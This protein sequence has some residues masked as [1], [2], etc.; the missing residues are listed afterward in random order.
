MCGKFPIK[1][2]AKPSAA[3]SDPAAERKIRRVREEWVFVTELKSLIY[4]KRFET[5]AVAEFATAGVSFDSASAVEFEHSAK[6]RSTDR[7]MKKK[8]SSGKK[9]ATAAG[10][11]RVVAANDRAMCRYGGMTRN[12]KF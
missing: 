3:G 11:G 10:A 5:P 9:S 2:R 12:M 8:F 6:G 4:C 7:T 1:K